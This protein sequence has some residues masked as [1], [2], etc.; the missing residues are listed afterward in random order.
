MTAE[1]VVYM[2]E[3]RLLLMPR[4]IYFLLCSR[5]KEDEVLTIFKGLAYVQDTRDTDPIAYSQEELS[6]V[7][8]FQT[9]EEARTQRAIWYIRCT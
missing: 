8:T 1:E 6:N 3:S 5:Y 9:I 2:V 4:D 7:N